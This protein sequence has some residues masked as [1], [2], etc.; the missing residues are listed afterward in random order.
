MPYIALTSELRPLLARDQRAPARARQ[1]STSLRLHCEP[2]PRACGVRATLSCGVT[3]SSS[4]VALG[5]AGLALLLALGC[6][7]FA[8]MAIWQERTRRSQR[9]KEAVYHWAGSAATK[10]ELEDL[11]KTVAQVSTQS[12]AEVANLRRTLVEMA[13]RLTSMEAEQ[14]SRAESGFPHSPRE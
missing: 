11:R 3:W 4:Q 8:W 7:L 13:E 14:Q 2:F 12:N 6:W 1:S 9:V 5:V 10:S